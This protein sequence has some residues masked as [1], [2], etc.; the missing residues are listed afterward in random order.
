MAHS[1]ALYQAPGRLVLDVG[2]KGFTFDVEIERSG[3]QGIDS[4]KVFCYDLMLARLWATKKLSPG[5]LVHDSTLFADVDER[6][7]ALALQLAEQVSREEGFQYICTL[8]SDKLPEEEFPASFD[9][10]KWVRLRLT[11]DQPEGSL[12]GFRF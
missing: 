2:P 12:L 4:M 9:I 1:E 11:D 10:E 7:C 6:Q 8:N 3:S 5:F